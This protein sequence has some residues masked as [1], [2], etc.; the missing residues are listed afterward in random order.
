MASSHF[1]WS[2]LKKNYPW[3]LLK[4]KLKWSAVKVSQSCPTLY[5]PMD[6]TVHGI[7][8]AR[9]LEWVAFPFSRGSS[10]P[11]DWTRVSCIASRFFTKNPELSKKAPKDCKEHFIQGHQD[12]YYCNRLSQQIRDWTPSESKRKSGKFIDKV[13]SG[14]SLDKKLI[15][16]SITDKGRG[17]WKKQL[18]QILA[19]GRPEW[20]GIR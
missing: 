15:R 9:I 8:P 17:F 16:V 7:L 11:R 19:E 12:E 4:T 18:N 1:F 14:W 20:S 13:Q 5:Y 3:H 2:L 10:Q 6:Y